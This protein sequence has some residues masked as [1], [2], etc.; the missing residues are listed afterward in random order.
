MSGRILKAMR[1]ASVAVAVW[2]L[3]LAGI[4]GT[5]VGAAKAA[6]AL[7]APRDVA[8]FCGLAA[9]LWAALVVTYAVFEDH[10]P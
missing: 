8:I 2:A 3:A 9:V 10:R 7:G 5:F 4:L 1:K 6:L